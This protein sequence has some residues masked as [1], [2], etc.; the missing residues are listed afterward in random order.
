MQ[1]DTYLMTGFEPGS[2]VLEM[3]LSNN[4]RPQMFP[5]LCYTNCCLGHRTL[6][7][8]FFKKKWANPGLFFVY[9]RSFQTNN[10]IFYNKSM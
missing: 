2:S 6:T 4:H 3:R 5:C 10:T 7:Y 1:V 9:F 8:F